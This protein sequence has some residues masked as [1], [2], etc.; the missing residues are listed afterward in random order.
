MSIRPNNA[1]ILFSPYLYVELTTESVLLLFNK[2]IPLG[3]V[4]NPVQFHVLGT[5]DEL[6]VEVEFSSI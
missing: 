3:P 6:Q 1:F 5:R 4:R 2:K